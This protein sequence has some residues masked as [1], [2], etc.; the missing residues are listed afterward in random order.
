MLTA[1]LLEQHQVGKARG[2]RHS[3]TTGLR[4]GRSLA[5]PCHAWTLE[6]DAA[7]M[8]GGDGAVG[9][10]SVRHL[11]GSESGHQGRKGRGRRCTGLPWGDKDAQGPREIGAT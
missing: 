4:A 2:P 1:F 11:W 7:Q 5:V 9:P 8:V 10:L 6:L 3:A